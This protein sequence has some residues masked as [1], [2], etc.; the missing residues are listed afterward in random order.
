MGRADDLCL[1]VGKQNR[2]TI[3]GYNPQK[4]IGLIRHHRVAAGWII[5]RNGILDLHNIGRMK[6][7]DAGKHCAGQ[8]RLHAE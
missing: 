1:G 6:L 8:D 5:L 3:G 7:M 2:D 4:H